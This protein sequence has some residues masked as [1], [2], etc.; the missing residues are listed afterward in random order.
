MLG[1]ALVSHPPGVGCRKAGG[2]KVTDLG[3]GDV[4]LVGAAE[5][6][7]LQQVVGVVTLVQVHEGQREGHQHDTPAPPQH[8]LVHHSH[9]NTRVCRESR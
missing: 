6:V 4:T 8:W 1:A 3:G 7:V 9:H 2:G 5:D